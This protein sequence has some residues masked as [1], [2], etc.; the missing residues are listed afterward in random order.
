MIARSDLGLG[1]AILKDFIS[2]S[3]VELL[4]EHFPKFV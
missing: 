2:P 4:V 1:N 3:V